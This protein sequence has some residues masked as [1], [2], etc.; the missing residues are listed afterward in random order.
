M[1]G[2]GAWHHSGLLSVI[3][4][5]THIP[6]TVMFIL[7]IP[8]KDLF[9]VQPFTLTWYCCGIKGCQNLSDSGT[10]ELNHLF[11]FPPAGPLNELV[12]WEWE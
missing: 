11:P 1:Y 3:L 10:G 4:N 9:H 2:R 7:I 5:E 8:C 12:S 6:R